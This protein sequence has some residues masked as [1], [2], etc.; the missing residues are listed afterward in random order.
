[1][2]YSNLEKLE[3]RIRQ[4][5]D[6]G[7]VNDAFNDATQFEHVA[8]SIEEA[9]ELLGVDASDIHDRLIISE[10]LFLS[11]AFHMMGGNSYCA[12]QCVVMVHELY[13]DPGSDDYV[14]MLEVKF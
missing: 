13:S 2:T 11:D 6:Y 12:A 7:Q 4:A 14:Y 9:A 5:D 3:Q 1:M 10:E 8:S